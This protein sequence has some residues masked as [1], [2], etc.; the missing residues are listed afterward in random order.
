[1]LCKFK[2]DNP[3]YTVWYKL[4]CCT[5]TILQITCLFP[6]DKSYL[7][8]SPEKTLVTLYIEIVV[9]FIIENVFYFHILY[10]TVDTI[11]PLILPYYPATASIMGKV[12]Y[13]SMAKNPGFCI[14]QG[15]SNFF[16]VA[17]SIRLNSIGLVF[18]PYL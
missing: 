11:V 13:T 16:L 3:T 17:I 14:M 5:C 4:S 18:T 15:N 6:L 9:T 1:M 10:I 2:Q 12:R 7:L 8:F